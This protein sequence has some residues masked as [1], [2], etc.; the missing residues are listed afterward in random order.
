MPLGDTEEVEGYHTVHPAART[1]PTTGGIAAIATQ[2]FSLERTFY[3][4]QGDSASGR[5]PSRN[6]KK[7]LPTLEKRVEVSRNCL[8]SEQRFPVFS[9]RIRTKGSEDEEEH[10]RCP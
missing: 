4:N 10:E 3:F 7:D 1:V 2:S 6:C 8:P 9:K 5:Y